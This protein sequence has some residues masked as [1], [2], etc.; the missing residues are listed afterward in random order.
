MSNRYWAI[1]EQIIYQPL[2]VGLSGIE[3]MMEQIVVHSF[4]GLSAWSSLLLASL[5]VASFVW[6]G[7]NSFYIKVFGFGKKPLDRSGLKKEA[8]MEQNYQPLFVVHSVLYSLL[9]ASLYC[10]L[11]YWPLCIALSFTG[12]SVLYSLLLASL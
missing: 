11:F 5:L 2:F 10:T 8:I 6:L 12:L 4:T 7:F 3:A 1:M 9:L